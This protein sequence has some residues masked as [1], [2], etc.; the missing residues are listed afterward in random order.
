MTSADEANW[1]AYVHRHPDSTH[2]HLTGWKHV[3]ENTYGHRSYYLLAEDG[4]EVVGLLPLFLIKSL[5]FG[6]Q[7]VSMP[8]LDCGG[9]LGNSQEVIEAL[10]RQVMKLGIELKVDSV[11]LRQTTPFN[12]ESGSWRPTGQNKVRMVLQLPPSSEDLFRS[13]KAKLRSQIRRP[14]KE[15]M[16][17]V[18]GGSELL[19]SFYEVF[20]TSM[21][22]LG[23][24]VHAAKL[25]REVCK[26]LNAK[27]SVVYHGDR[28][29]AAA[30]MILFH[31]NA[32]IPWASSLKK[33][34]AF[35]PNMLLYWTLLEYACNQG[36]RYFD[37]GRSTNGEG[38][39]RFKLQWGTDPVPLNWRKWSKDGGNGTGLNTHRA[40]FQ[41]ASK[42]WQRLPLPVTVWLGPIARK[43]I[44]L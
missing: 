31:D 28:P 6:N 19:G 36:G 42:T 24:P 10:V 22:D 1:D 44:S 5:L 39:Y 2:C 32:Q 18:L 35:S 34:N 37:F 41:L 12:T 30:I 7:L 8:F 17:K 21:R 26:Q 38:T 25:F 43:Y 15:G 20:S 4:P 29:A 11:E 33:Y 23:S 40:T 3:I 16:R 14:Q 27:V 9:V 13:F